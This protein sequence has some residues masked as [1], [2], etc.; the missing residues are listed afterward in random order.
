MLK[1]S[2]C[3]LH[4]YIPQYTGN[5]DMKLSWLFVS[6][7]P[8]P[9]M[10]AQLWFQQQSNY[11]Q[12]Q[13]NT[14]SNYKSFQEFDVTPTP[15]VFDSQIKFNHNVYIRH[16]EDNVFMDERD[17]KVFGSLIS[18]P[19]TTELSTLSSQ[20]SNIFIGCFSGFIAV[21]VPRLILFQFKN[22]YW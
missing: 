14:E 6:Q 22:I 7:A 20:E 18:D 12:R 5:N 11:I 17:L 16:K 1:S 9:S 13:S 15:S 21:V 4:F 8:T 3:D 10:Q 19:F 2:T